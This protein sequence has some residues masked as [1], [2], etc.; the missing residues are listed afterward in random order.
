LS[1]CNTSNAEISLEPATVDRRG[2]ELKM[3]L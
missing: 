2:D 1:Q 3:S